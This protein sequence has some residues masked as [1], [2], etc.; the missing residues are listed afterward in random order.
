M[1]NVISNKNN[2]NLSI[3][4]SLKKSLILTFNLYFDYNHNIQIQTVNVKY[5]VG[6]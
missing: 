6:L 5:L 1:I 3:K 2:F 4:I